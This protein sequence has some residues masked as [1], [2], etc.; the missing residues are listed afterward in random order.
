MQNSEA[1][2]LRGASFSSLADGCRI[3]GGLTA[4]I[5]GLI[6]VMKC[7][8]SKMKKSG[9]AIKAVTK[10]Y[11]FVNESALIILLIFSFNEV[12]LYCLASF[13]IASETDSS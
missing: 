4:S 7:I 8:L 2:F 13:K 12:T 6:F 10:V 1:L 11:N 5:W 9:K 3:I